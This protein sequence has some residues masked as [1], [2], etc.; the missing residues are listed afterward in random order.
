MPDL[1]THYALSYL[2]ASRAL[3]R[4]EALLVAF[5]GLLPDVDALLRIHRWVTHSLVLAVLLFS[6]LVLLASQW[7]R[8]RTLV[9]VALALYVLH[10]ALD[11]FTAPTPVFWPLDAR[12]YYVKVGL[13]G[14]VSGGGIQLV[15]SLKLIAT[16]SD[17]AV[18]PV[19]E[20]PL[21]T[22]TGIITSIAVAAALAA[23]ALAKKH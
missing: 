21:I 8:A 19:L 23:E 11:V 1:A 18:K 7:K 9:L 22:A 6:G 10:I 14:S 5:I 2:V 20:A 3:S 15:P 13:E 16:E 17:F 4:R 12:S